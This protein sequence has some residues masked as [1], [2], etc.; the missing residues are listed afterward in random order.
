LT[1]GSIAGIEALDNAFLRQW[2][3]KQY[4]LYY[5]TKFGSL[6]R[7][8]GEFVYDFSNRFNKMYN[9]IPAKIKPTK[10]S[11][12]ITYAIAFDPEFFLLLRERRY[13]SLAHM[14]DAT[15][16]VESNIVAS[17]KLRGKYDRDKRKNRV[18]ASTSDSSIAHPQVDELTKLVKSL[19]AEM[20]KL[21]LEGKH[22]YRNI[23]N[24]DNIGKF[25]RPNNPPQILPRDPR[26]RDSDDQKVQAPLQNNPVV[27][28]EGEDEE[29]DPEI[30]FLSD[31][32]SS[33]DLTQSTY[34]ESLMDNQINEL[35]KGE[36]TKENS[37]RYNLRSKNKE[38]KTDTSDHPTKT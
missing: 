13:A 24:D 10:T 12:K 32:S 35:S 3:D 23:Q 4:F 16:E 1:P 27:D 8:E 22:T 38:E 33:P 7:K 21:K 2:G 34:E 25:R 36:K 17:D 15:L 11:A 6:K 19:F 18:E 28:E 29:T 5:I 20:E 37:N 31:T 9:E 14:Q 30:H 26:N